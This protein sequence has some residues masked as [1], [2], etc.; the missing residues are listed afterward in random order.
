MR[1]DPVTATKN[2]ET[3]RVPI[4]PDMENWLMRMKRG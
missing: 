1:G 2:S 3:R 4:L